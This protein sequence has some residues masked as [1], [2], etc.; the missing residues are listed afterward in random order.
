MSSQSMLRASDEL[1]AEVQRS[2]TERDRSIC[3]LVHEHS[4][5][6]AHQL[7]EAFFDTEPRARLRLVHLHRHRLMDR[8]RPYESL[9]SA[10]YHYVIGPLGARVI[11]SERGIELSELGY[12]PERALAWANS[13]RLRHLVGVNGIFTSLLG[14]ARCSRGQAALEEWWSERQCAKAMA[15]LVNPDG[16]GVWREGARVTEFCLEYDR[17]TETLERLRS[18]LIGYVKLQRATGVHR[19]VLFHL[20]SVEREAGTRESLQ[21][22]MLPVATTHGDADPAEAVWLP[23]ESGASRRRLADLN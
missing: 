3:R 20:P 7:I 16:Y 5:L 18:K 21:G 10:P 22:A 6:T 2:L 4:V 23:L 8:F 15:G 13:P 14:T 9:G 1:F 12:R 19:W 17:G 11:A